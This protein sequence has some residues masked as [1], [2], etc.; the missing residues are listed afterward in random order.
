VDDVKLVQCVACGGIYRPVQADGTAYYHACPSR[1]VVGAK[2]APTADDPNATVPVFAPI[3]NRRDENIA[4]LDDDGK[5]I[6]KREGAGVRPV[7]DDDVIARFFG[8]TED[9]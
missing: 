9:A 5:A 8:S 3:A 7:V 1:R 2:P 6:I 4:R